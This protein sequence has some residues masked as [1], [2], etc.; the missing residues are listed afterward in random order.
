MPENKPAFD[1]NKPYTPVSNSSGEKPPF[2]PNETFTPVNKNAWENFDPS[3]NIKDENQLENTLNDIVKTSKGTVLE[4]EKDVLR[5]I[6]KNPNTTPDQAKE[7][8]QTIQGYHPKFGGEDN[9][10]YYMKQEDNGVLVPKPLAYGEKPPKGYNVASVW[11]NQK[12]ANDDAW[13]T[14]LGKSLYN[15]VVGAVQGTGELLQTGIMA[16][17]G[18]ESKS[19]N[20][21]TNALESLKFNKDEALN[22]P[23][24]NTEGISEWA[25]LL[26][27]KRF[28]ISPEALWGTL[29]MTAESV[30][31]FL[32]GAKVGSEYAKGIT[33]AKELSKAGVSASAFTGSYISQ[34]GDNLDDAREAGLKGLDAAAY[35]STITA[36]QAAIDA[37]F[38]ILPSV[39]KGYKGVIKKGESDI[40]KQFA[41]GAEKTAEGT[42]TEQGFKDVVKGTALAYESKLQNAITNGLIDVGKEGA[43]E[44]GQDFV[45][46]AGQQLYDKLTDEEKAKFGTDA[47]SAKS[48]GSYIENLAAGLVGGGIMA[49]A[50]VNV[51]KQYNDQS[52]NALKIVEGGQDKINEFKANVYQAARRGELTEQERDQAINKV[53][54]YNKYWDQT[55]DLPNMDIKEK[56]KAFELSYNIEGLKS[57]TDFTEDE[58][59]QLD[60]IALGKI[61]AKK[62]IIKGL[63]KDLNHI[64]LRQDVQKET[65]IGQ[66]TVNKVSKAEEPNDE[67]PSLEGLRRK[68][69]PKITKAT[70]VTFEEEP[71]KRRKISDVSTPE[72]NK[73]TVSRPLEIKKILQEHLKSTPDNQI[74]A[75][76]RSG[77]NGVLTAD[78]G[79]NKQVRF[80]QSAKAQDA[81]SPSYFKYENLPKTKVY[82]ENAGGNPNVEQ[83]G[84]PVFYYEEQIPI[85][86]LEIDAYDESGKPEKD[87]NGNQ[88]R[89][90]VL[91]AYNPEI[92][93]KNNFIG[94]VREHDKGKSN[95]ADRPKEVEQLQKIINANLLTDEITQFKVKGAVKETSSSKWNRL[96]EKALSERELDAIT[97]QATKV[98]EYTPELLD[99]ISKKRE[100]IVKKNPFK[101]NKIKFEKPEISLNFIEDAAILKKVIGSEKRKTKLGKVVEIKVSVAKKQSEIKAKLERLKKLLD[102]IHGH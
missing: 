82:T 56:R 88:K 47:L 49:P 89:K 5:D 95:Y 52:V 54:A 50:S 20:S 28:D 33:G 78:I 75:T 67:R 79:E 12:Q 8:I 41:K 65:R 81:S 48:F 74:M 61:D 45:A 34:I 27:K 58:L 37:K 46:K 21:A 69:K 51:K 80:A 63:Q 92:K 73:L 60:P 97:D 22:K 42:L 102:C 62:E 83:E 10:S 101:A 1:P 31:S 44:L 71:P 57:E 35:A 66:D 68:L 84:E 15:G 38:G 9:T 96:V 6:L 77:Q 13:Y 100:Q 25:D 91:V 76:I 29:N 86:R 16:A 26:D 3:S 93:D 55:K 64:L 7:A 53:D 30:A 94:F 23:I 43:Q 39:Y 85:K 99:A 17:T 18:D 2:N 59:K 36:A 87:A 19:L 72:W 14:D 4:H 90:A 70:E 24:Y 40:I 98:D 32:T 11:G